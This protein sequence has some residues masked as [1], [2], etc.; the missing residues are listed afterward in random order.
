MRSNSPFKYRSPRVR[1]IDYA[2]RSW[3]RLGFLTIVCRLADSATSTTLEGITSRFEGAIG[4]L[5]DVPSE[6]ADD[7]DSYLQTHRRL[8]SNKAKSAKVQL[9]DIY[10]SDSRLPSHSGAI[11]GDMNAAGY[12]HSVHV[13]IPSW[14][15]RLRLIRKENYTLT[16]RGKTL[17]A[18]KNPARLPI[19]RFESDWNPLLLS[20]GERYLYL[21]CLLDSDGDLIRQIFLNLE[22]RGKQFSRSEIGEIA[23][24]SLVE[25]SNTHLRR[26]YSGQSRAMATAISNTVNS[27]ATQ[28]GSAM[29]P[30]ESIA[31]PRTEPLVDCRILDRPDESIY[32][33]QVSNKAIGFLTGL[34]QSE[35]ID[36][37]LEEKLASCVTGLTETNYESDPGKVLAYM[38]QSYKQL[39]SG[40]GYCSIRE[41]ASLA[42]ALALNSQSGFFE[43]RDVEIAIREA[44]REYGK[45][46]R[47]AKSRQGD[48]AQL[49]IDTKLAARLADG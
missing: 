38:A 13:E 34:T 33:Y 4:S 2:R 32:T 22:F 10:L 8:P 25:I 45:Q 29:G 16:N 12:R 43:L 23:A 11:T 7:V 42:V 48:I 47:F 35:T 30:R 9:Q 27:I 40:M 49:R 21:N 14:A 1:W 36:E 15:V 6:M 28:K 5:Q 39:R 26:S 17:M 3:Q 37:F 41:V 20:P 44:G 18:I 24:A 31:T 19:D 46:I